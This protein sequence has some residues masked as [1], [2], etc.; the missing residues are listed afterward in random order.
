MRQNYSIILTGLLV[1]LT[2]LT[3]IS[4]FSGC[5]GIQ[6]KPADKNYFELQITVPASAPNSFFIGDPLLVRTFCIN[7]AFDS[8]SFVYLIEK[9]EYVTDYYNEFIYSPTRLITEK[10][11]EN[12]YNSNHFKPAPTDSRQDITYLLSGKITRLYGDFQATNDPSAIIEIRM[13]LKKNTGKAFQVISSKTY[14]AQEPILSR[15]PAHLVF[16]WNKGLAK[17]MAQFISD[18]SKTG[19]SK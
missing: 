11:A 3:V 16:G 7:P 18:F 19:L 8:H 17:I 5:A 13:I 10:I 9:N 6:T 1:F 2:V 4:V 15:N 12:L 14:L